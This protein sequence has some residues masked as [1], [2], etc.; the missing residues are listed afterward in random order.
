MKNMVTQAEASWLSNLTIAKEKNMEM[1][2]NQSEIERT[3]NRD[4]RNIDRVSEYFS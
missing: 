3:R 4:M 1:L 2:F